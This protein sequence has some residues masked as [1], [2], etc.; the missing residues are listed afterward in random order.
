LLL[1][2]AL[3]TSAG[4]GP[5]RASLE[6]QYTEA[7]LQFLQGFTE[8]PLQGADAGF[9]ASTRY[10]DL[11]WKFRILA[12]E[13]NARK[14]RVERALDLLQ[15]EPPA[16][17]P[18]E[19]IWERILAQASALCQSHKVDEAEK[20]FAQ[21]ASLAGA[22]PDKVAELLYARGRCGIF[23]QNWD[24]AAR[25]FN[26]I[27]EAGPI[28][29]PFLR[30]YV[31]ANLG[32]AVRNKLQYEEAVGWYLKALP[33]AR[34]AG[35]THLEQ[36]ILENLGL[37]YADL[38]DFPNARVNAIAAQKLA[39]Q[40]KDS[41]SEQRILI[42]LARTQQV[43]G[44]SG[45][46]EESLKRALDIASK[47][48]NNDVAA[49]ALL[50]LS[51]IKLE[52]QKP[53]QS[54]EYLRQAFDLHLDGE[55]LEGWKLNQARLLGAKGEY[56]KA[57]ASL[58]DQLHSVE[59][60]DKQ[61]HTVHYRLRWYIQAELARDYA[62]GNDT[63]EAE[64]WFQRGID[65]A[66]EAANRM[67]S[68]EFRTDI[69][70]NMPVFDDY[71]TFLVE[72]QQK[73]KALQVAQLGRARTLMAATE[74]PRRPVNTQAWI[75]AI[76]QYLHRNHAVLLSY[77]ATDKN[78][79]LWTLNGSQLRFSPLG[80]AGPDLDTLIDS[81][82]ATIERHASLSDSS[83]A[84]KLFQ[85]L[86]QPA[87]DLV[88]KGAHVMILAD[89]KIY[90][91]NFETLVSPQGGDHYWIRDVDIQN[92]SSIDLLVTPNPKRRT[93][94]D[95][96]LIGAPAQ[97]DPH[98]VE[99]PNAR[100]EMESVGRHFS[101]N[102]VT[103]ISGK[104]ATPGSY[105]NALPG[106]Y[107]YIHLATHG[108]ANAME[109]LKS[110]VILSAGADGSFKL[111]AQDIIS[112]KLHLNAQL[113]TISAC[114][115]AGTNIQSLE[116]LLGLESAFMRA[117][118][119]QVVAALWDVDDAITPKLMDDFYAQLRQGRSASEALRHSKLEVLNA[120]GKYATPY[121]WAALQLYTGS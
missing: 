101:S 63:A 76:Q 44:Q 11:N 86:V 26:S 111:L 14:G 118:A 64:K 31:P 1:P 2:L 61:A 3:L 70:D 34:S 67:K 30:A 47:L 106:L 21:A 39:E 62:A 55:N 91:I 102:E 96:L 83:A 79:Y 116:G 65:T 43:E 88:P 74:R 53:D 66:E 37:L 120:G 29:D 97:A 94:R 50:S 36:N 93:T 27:M 49:R 85:I 51:A 99:L 48:H 77:F 95:L 10:P 20:P 41:A 45:A 57:T 75:T 73:E 105:S 117:G 121:Y 112:P 38:R 71:V 5:T 87:A 80:I 69:R 109:P 17:A 98:F 23:N 15:P 4:C 28:A 103:S 82:K 6:R 89:S 54:E 42:D 107:K 19:V 32:W 84:K 81:Y 104:D 78:C 40:A 90:S 13:T 46:A 119:H 22:Q 8:Q 108:S 52:Q 24:S 113:V 115:G 35:A 59:E 7:R 72:H 58:L 9:R 92:A 16:N 33:A 100:Q 12:A 25:Y 68:E 18:P 56:A 60:A 114:E 110:A